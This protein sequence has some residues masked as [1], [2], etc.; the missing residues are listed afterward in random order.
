MPKAHT[1]NPEG[2]VILVV[3]STH[4]NPPPPKPPAKP[5]APGA[6][7]DALYPVHRYDTFGRKICGEEPNGESPAQSDND[8]EMEPA[9]LERE[10]GIRVPAKYLMLAP[11]RFKRCLTGGFSEAVTLAE[12]GTVD[13]DVPDWDADAMLILMRLIMLNLRRT[14]SNLVRISSPRLPCWPTTMVA[15]PSSTTAWIYG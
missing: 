15:T 7:V 6:A 4:F 11:S 12:K 8:E 13:I 2:E 3:T 1:L 14:R 10:T 5:I 9:N